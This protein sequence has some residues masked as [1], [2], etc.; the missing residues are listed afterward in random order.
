M[1]LSINGKRI[2]FVAATL[3]AALAMAAC[4]SG[5]AGDDIDG[6]GDDVKVVTTLEVFADLVTQVGGERVAVD[7]LLPSG[8][9]AH[10]YEPVPSALRNVTEA[11]LAFANG[12]GLEA[13]I[14]RVLEGNLPG[15]APLIELGEEAR[16]AGAEVIGGDGGDPHLWLD[17]DIYAEYARAVLDALSAADPQGAV[18]YRSNHD[19]YVAELEKMGEDVLSRLSEVPSERRKLVTTHDAF[20]YLARYIGFDVDAVV[21]PNPGQEPSARDVADLVEAIG[22]TGVSAVF[23]EPQLGAESEV[24]RRVAADVGVE[25]CTLYSGS[26]DD[27]IQTY[28]EMMRFNAEE[29]VRCLGGSDG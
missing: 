4:G 20:S 8:A 13:R 3:G 27:R 2:G 11:D 23:E 21:A 14:V 25:V 16:E 18:D 17:I 10:T 29:L 19:R 6:Q 24:L 26:L 28:V 15:D 22:Y 5:G 12:L 9:D 1:I 7:F